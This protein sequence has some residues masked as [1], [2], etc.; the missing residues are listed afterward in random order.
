MRRLMVIV[1]AAVGAL[2]L[3]A[4][5]GGEVAVQ[6]QI[7]EREAAPGSETEVVALADLP[8]KLLPFN[9]DALFDSLAAAYAERVRPEPQAPDSL[10]ALQ[11][12]IIAARAAWQ[13][14]ETEWQILRDSLEALSEELEGLSRSDPRYIVLFRDF[15]DLQQ[16]VQMLRAQSEEAFQRFTALQERFRSAAREIRLLQQEWADQAFADVD[17]IIN[18][19][20]E[21]LDRQIHVDTTSASGV[22]TFEVPGGEWWVYARRD[23]AF[24]ELYWNEP[25]TVEGGRVEVLLNRESA[26]VRREL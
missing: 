20:L 6:A 24:G 22:V 25:I 13:R 8:V 19:R 3:G 14:A 1:A 26:E 18:V 4:C 5:G 2:A 21:R 10:L 9:R 11:D 16:R 12:S 17:S 15:Q 23:M 7:E